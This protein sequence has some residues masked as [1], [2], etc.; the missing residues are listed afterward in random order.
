[1]ATLSKSSGRFDTASLALIPLAI[2][3]NIVIGTLVTGT[4]LYLDSIGT[5]LVGALLGP[6]YALL[7]GVLANLIWTYVFGNQYA[8]AFSYVS[9]AIGMIAG[10]A[11]QA[12]AFQRSSPR[13]LSAAI[14]AIFVFALATMVIMF[15]NTKDGALPVLGD[16][17]GANLIILVAAAVVGGLLGYFVLKNAGYAGLAGLLTGVVAA[18]LSA[19]MSAIQ[20][21]GVT[22]GGT[23][24][25]V[26]A[27]RASGANVMTSVLAQGSVSD[28]FDK[29]TSFMLVWLIVQSLPKSLLLRFPVTRKF[30]DL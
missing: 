26:A 8:A 7:T 12:G 27:F 24:L 17:I 19:P 21:G 5:V 28:P 9:A 4:P 14:G 1:M 22:G 10:F 29:M 16:I 20:F 15:L 2:A 18:L 3:I 25:L 23:D 6:W 30:A 13:S 11:A